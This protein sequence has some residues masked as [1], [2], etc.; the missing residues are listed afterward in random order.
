MDVEFD[1][2][3]DRVNR[4]KHGVALAFGVHV[5]TMPDCLILS[6]IRAIDGEARYKAIGM[7]DGKLWTAVHVMRGDTVRLISVRWSDDGE[8]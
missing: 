7:I 5:S 3:K 2:A 8:E 6:S 1:G 4:A